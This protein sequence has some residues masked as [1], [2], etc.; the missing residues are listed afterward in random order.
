MV[1]K[2]A[3]S[4]KLNGINKKFL[5]DFQVNFADLLPLALSLTRKSSPPRSTSL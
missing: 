3:L 5:G 2:A 1:A 4:E